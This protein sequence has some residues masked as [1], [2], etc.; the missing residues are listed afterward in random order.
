MIHELYLQYLQLRSI[1]GHAEALGHF[2]YLHP[3]TFSRLKAYIASQ[4][5]GGS[6]SSEQ[7][8]AG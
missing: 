1:M 2:D 3:V 5:D 4:H 6:G 8:F 7:A